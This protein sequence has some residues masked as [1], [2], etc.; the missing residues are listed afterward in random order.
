MK[1]WALADSKMGYVW[2]WKLY[3]GKEDKEGPEPLGERV[4]VGLLTGL[5]NKRYYVY[6]DNFYTSPTLCKHLLTLGFGSCG[7]VRLDRR[8]IPA[9]FKEA[10]PKKGDIA[11]YHDEAILGLKWKDKRF[12]SML[13]TIH[14]DSMVS[15]DRRSRQA[16]AGVETVQKPHVIEE[17][18]QCMGGVDKSDQLVTYY[19]FRHCSKKWWKRGFLHLLELT[20]VNALILYCFNTPKKE[21]MAHLKFSLDIASA[22]LE[23]AQPVPALRYQPS[24]AAAVVPLRLTGR[25]FPEP[26]A[27]RPDCK[28]CTNRTAG[29]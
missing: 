14:D 1:A 25:H 10:A 9:T 15:K 19:G 16:P 8:N 24:P 28:V 11:T 12:V 23:S 20:M 5:E 3:C 2:N 26:A 17:Y 21:R 4:V 18:N 29:K 22:L 7:T 6:F 27:G 13:S